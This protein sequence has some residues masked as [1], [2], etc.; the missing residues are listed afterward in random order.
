MSRL[1]TGVTTFYSYHCLSGC[2]GGVTDISTECGIGDLSLNSGLVFAFALAHTPV[3]KACICLLPLSYGLNK[4]SSL[5]W[6]EKEN[7][8]L[9]IVEKA[10]GKT[11]LS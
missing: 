2:A 11:L 9:H 3:G 5:E 10:V 7:P 6:R 1:K 4:D 8:E